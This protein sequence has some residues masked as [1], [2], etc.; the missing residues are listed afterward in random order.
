[1]CNESRRSNACAPLSDQDFARVIAAAEIY[2]SSRSILSSVIATLG[3]VVHRGLAMVPAE[4]RE[5]ITAKIHETLVVVQGP[6]VWNMDDDPGRGSK[7]WLYTASVIA[8][9]I[10]GGAGGL[11]TLLVELPITTGLMLRS[12]ADTGRAHGGRIEDPL[13]RA[14]CI[15][16]FAYGTPIEEDDE[17]LTFLAARL[18]AVKVAEATAEVIAKVAARYAA[19]LGP[20]IAARSV[21]VTGAFLGAALNWSYMSFYQSMAQVLF[22]LFPIEWKH[23]PAQVRSCFASVVRELREK[24]VTRLRAPRC[25]RYLQK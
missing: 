6:A 7:E 25:D 2:L 14:T 3:N 20:Q 10:A 18:G 12:I 5:P 22:T 17:E 15:E 9:G 4:W 19:V 13:F 16:V 8:A 1:M 23:D 21:P 11:P 24:Q